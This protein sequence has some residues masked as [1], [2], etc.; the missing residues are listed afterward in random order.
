VLARLVRADWIVPN[1]DALTVNAFGKLAGAAFGQASQGPRNPQDLNRYAYAYNNPVRFNDPSGHIPF[2]VAAALVGGAVNTAMY[3]FQAGRSGATLGGA[4]AAFASGAAG[5]ALAVG[6]LGMGVVGL[7]VS[8]IGG[9]GVD[10]A[11]Q[12]L[13]ATIDKALPPSQYGGGPAL[14]GVDWGSAGKAGTVAAA[15]SLG[16]SKFADTGGEVITPKGNKVGTKKWYEKAFYG[17]SK[18]ARQRP[19][20]S[21][22]FNRLTALRNIALAT[23][24]GA[25]LEGVYEAAANSVAPPRTS[26]PRQS[27]AR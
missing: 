2:L 9:V 25:M 27:S 7:G 18:A 12:Q 17:T 19:G 23:G 5:G 26:P 8:V 3:L 20:F 1:A 13:G 6:T 21:I 24:I 16:V 15:D 4:V 22:S 14:E 10:L 11:A